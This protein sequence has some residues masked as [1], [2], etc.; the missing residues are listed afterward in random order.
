MPKFDTEETQND[1]DT[2]EPELAQR[3][4]AKVHTSVARV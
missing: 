1:S 2:E 3:I 4:I